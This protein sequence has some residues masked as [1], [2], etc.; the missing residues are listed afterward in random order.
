MKFRDKWKIAG[1]ISSEVRFQSQLDANPMNRSRIKENPEKILK[2]IKSGTRMSSVLLSF[3]IMMLA[4]ISIAAGY[5]ETEIAPFHMRMSISM[6]L[7]LGFSFILI[8]FL[9]LIATTGFFNSSTMD[10]PSTLPFTRDDLEN[11]LVLSFTRVFIA[12]AIIINLVY[13]LICC[14]AMGLYV[15][16]I[17][18]LG[19]LMTTALSIGA[20]IKVSKW[21]YIKSHSATESKASAAI[22]IVAGLGV[23]VGMFGT[24]SL[25]GAIPALV[26]LITSISVGI[27][28]GLMQLLALVFPFSIAI[29]AMS[30]TSGGF[31]LTTIIIAG[32]ASLFYGVAAVQT[33]RMSGKSL[34]S[35][36]AKGVTKSRSESHREIFVD[37]TRPISGII[38]K[39][40]KLATRNIGSIMIIVMPILMMFSVYPIVALSSGVFLR[41]TS[42]IIGIAY[43]SSFTGLSFMGLLGLDSEGGSLHEGLPISTKMILTAKVRVFSVQFVLAMAILFVWYSLANPISPFII[44]IP[45]VQIPC[46]Y[47]IGIMIGAIVYLIRGGGRVV[48]VNIAG[49]QVIVFGAILISAVINAIPLGGYALMIVLTQNHILAILVQL[50]FAVVSSILV[51]RFAFRFLKD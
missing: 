47:A 7:F 25:I 29:F 46:S 31:Q 16:L 21:F 39:D 11:L 9:N 44:L 30:L 32:L 28:D 41:S 42:A 26:E 37:V 3:F 12:P 49:D 8:F 51:N 50:T 24:Y 22:R 43:I 35:I 2:Q 38:R 36:A 45:L 48:A 34:R 6:A 19:C 13:P 4:I 17:A 33:Y 40:M 10:L 20:L 1:I 15:G 23:V 27:G 5:F 18:L 14:F